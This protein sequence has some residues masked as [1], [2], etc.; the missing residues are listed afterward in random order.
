MKGELSPIDFALAFVHAMRN[1]FDLSHVPSVRTS[2]ALPRFLSARRM[3][4]GE[5]SPKDFVEAAVYLTPL[6]DQAAAF[7]VAREIVFPKEKSQPLSTTPK[8]KEGALGAP[9]V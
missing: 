9:V 5:L 2:V 4:T 8:A 7:E 1:R 3:R 6:E